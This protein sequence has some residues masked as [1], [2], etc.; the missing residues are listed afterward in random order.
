MPFD[1]RLL[2]ALS[3]RQQPDGGFA[4]YYTASGDDGEADT[5][6]TAYALR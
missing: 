3:A 5:P 4:A 6:T 2:D 1:K